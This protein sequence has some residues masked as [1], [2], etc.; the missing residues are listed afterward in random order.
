MN[1]EL[2]NLELDQLLKKHPHLMELQLNISRNLA[3]LDN[4]EDRMYYMSMELLDSFYE[5]KGKLNEATI[6]LVKYKVKE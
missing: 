6:M 2:L 4:S 3:R 5:L 1:I